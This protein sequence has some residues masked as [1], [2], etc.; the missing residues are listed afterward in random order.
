MT[1]Q[2][3]CVVGGGMLG[4]TVALRLAQAGHAVTLLEAAPTLGG[5]ASAWQLDAPDGPVVW[6]RHYHVTL[7]SDAH[8]RGVLRE[9]GLDDDMR[10]VETRTGYWANGS[11]YSASNT[12]EF[13]RLPGLRLVDK[14]RI[15][16]TIVYASRVRDWDRLSRVDAA[17]WLRK[18]SGRRAFERFWEPQLRAKLGDAYEDVAASFIWAT[19]Q[20]LYAARRSG[21]KKEMFGY[22]PGGYARVLEVF[23]DHLRAAGV[24][25]R[26][27]SRV[28]GIERVDDHVV[29]HDAGGDGDAYDDVIVTVASPV[30]AELCRGLSDDEYDR[31]RGARYEGIVCVSLLLR[32]P[33]SGY[34]L[35]YLSETMPFTAVVEMSAFVDRAQ[36]HGWSLVYLPKYVAPDDPLFSRSDDEILEE[37]LPALSRVYPQVSAASVVSARV[38]RVRHV[39]AVPTVGFMDRLP[40]TRTSQPG[41]HLVSSANI[42]NGTLNVDETVALAERTV[43]EV[44]AERPASVGHT[45]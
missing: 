15:G 9:L 8:N 38:S 21:L 37:F 11:M 2:R 31:L 25:V 19:I 34:Y 10:W 26:T 32:E 4:M 35:T 20:R 39:F 23:A 41:L 7:L 45:A 28:S 36:L 12:L 5:L 1:T 44:L 27:G 6:D 42:A 29:V 40:P 18:W 3:F 14:L 30:A 33:L 43:R 22:V 17:S 13:L 16:G 24:D